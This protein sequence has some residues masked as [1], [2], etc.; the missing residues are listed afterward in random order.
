L[1]CIY[2]Y[3]SIMNV[4]P[5]LLFSGVSSNVHD[6]LARWCAKAEERVGNRLGYT[7]D[8]LDKNKVP[9]QNGRFTETY[10]T[11]I[12]RN[13]RDQKLLVHQMDLCS[14]DRINMVIQKPEPTAPTPV[15]VA[16]ALPE[17]VHTEIET[18]AEIPPAEI[19]PE[20]PAVLPPIPPAHKAGARNIAAAQS[21]VYHAKVTAA[22][23]S[24]DDDLMDAMTKA[25]KSSQDPVSTG[26]P[27][28][29]ATTP[30]PPADEGTKGPMVLPIAA[31]VAAV[32]KTDKKEAAP[33]RTV[34]VT[35]TPA[36]VQVSP[37][38]PALAPI[39]PPV[40]V[41]IVA[42]A[43]TGIKNMKPVPKGTSMAQDPDQALL[44]MMN[45]AG[46]DVGSENK[47]KDTKPSFMELGST[48]HHKKNHQEDLSHITLEQWMAKRKSGGSKPKVDKEDDELDVSKLLNDVSITK[49]LAVHPLSFL[50]ISRLSNSFSLALQRQGLNSP[51]LSQ[52]A[53]TL[54]GQSE[55]H[56]VQLLKDL[57]ETLA[58]KESPEHVLVT[59]LT[60]MLESCKTLDTAYAQDVKDFR[61]YLK[62][63]QDNV[64]NEQLPVQKVQKELKELDSMT[65]GEDI[66]L[67]LTGLEKELEEAQKKEKVAPTTLL[68]RAVSSAL[69]EVGA[70]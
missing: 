31:A 66:K 33:P 12:A 21:K 56:S 13:T 69:A 29:V 50:Q 64:R 63:L 22:T 9:T 61:D 43:T 51:A 38:A 3:F 48:V 52:L 8:L 20:E 68:Q 36:L 44:D 47:N 30:T 62:K 35:N 60:A 54:Q 59:H 4:I 57:R 49:P 42:P 23:M 19:I 6:D 11:L 27:N 5:I 18:N 10:A 41:P 53:H 34:P 24:G 14:W 16:A 26:T 25:I 58:H 45:Q 1:C 55:E 32:E 65:I 40:I 67:P 2:L 37:S 46:Y 28:A 15:A 39:V 17:P 70:W 7:R